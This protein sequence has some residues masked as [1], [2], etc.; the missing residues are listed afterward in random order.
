MAQ[1]AKD[2][3]INELLDANS[4]LNTTVKHLVDALTQK[5]KALADMQ[6]R[7]DEMTEELKLLRKKLFGS[8]TEHMSNP[9][10]NSDQ[11]TIYPFLGIEPEKEPEP[12]EAEYIE[13]Q[14]YTKSKKAKSTLKEQF[15]NI[16]VKQVFIDSLSDE[17]KLCPTCGTE[18]Q[19]IGTEIIRRE[20]IHVK[21]SMYMLEYVGTTYGC[22]V[23]KDTEDPQFVKDNKAPAALI[24]GS[25]TSPSLASWILYEKFAKS[26]PF[27]RL[28]KSLEELGA[29][30]SRTT[31]ANWAIQCNSLYFKHLTD[32]FH[33]ELLKRKYLMMDET[34]IQV[35]H[36]PGRTPESKSYVWLMRSGNDGLPPI[37]YYRYA[38]TRSGD[39]A[40]EL[41]DGI[42]PGTYLMC[43]GFSG[44]N[45][46]KDVRR[47][48]CYA[49]IRRYFYEAIP[50][51]HDRDITNPAVQGVMYCNKLFSYENKYAERHYKP[52]TIKKRRL[53]D[54]KPVIKAFLDWADKQVVTGNSKFA[55]A[56]T[57]LKNR[58]NDL[59]T[60]LEDG[61]C[62]LS[63]NW[64]ENSIRPVTVG[65]KNWLFSSS[66]DGAEASMNI[67]TIIEM[68]KLHGLNR[69]K[70]LEYI[71]EHRPS[72]EMTDEELS[73]LT[74]WNKDVQETCGKCDH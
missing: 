32:Y 33:R 10:V 65:R 26:V 31:M 37:I 12:I 18:M 16:P 50:A 44:Y 7:L 14:S 47:C 52:E 51:G 72:A 55:K 62:S 29:K 74:P 9:Y 48:T 22:P 61:H 41:T 30:V 15:S 23:C 36:E 34:P 71:L 17:D 3:R 54:E 4:Q 25:Y 58:R 1:S 38:P 63:N 59:M 53:K 19:P 28:E 40:L 56:L 5:D 57:Y 21:P 13:I 43:D 39:V 73:L 64:S 35:L 67:Y 69:Q 20:V 68:A 45:K 11:L 2:I 49:H 6:T 60:Y 46:L 8:S 66:V 27:Y 70:Y 42:Q 24:K